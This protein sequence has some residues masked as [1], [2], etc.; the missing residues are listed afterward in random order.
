MRVLFVNLPY[1][2]RFTRRYMCTYTSAS[3]LFPPYELMSVAGEVRSKGKYEVRLIDCVAENLN[4]EYLNKYIDD[5]QPEVIL[6]LIGLD[7]FERDIKAINAIKNKFPQIIQVGFGHYPT[8]FPEEIL[9]KSSLDII[10]KGEPDEVMSD[11]MD[12]INNPEKLNEIQGIAFKN[13]DGSI[14]ISKGKK[15]ILDLNNLAF[16]AHDLIDAKKYFEPFL[17]SPFGMIQT[18]RG[19]PYACNFCVTSYGKKYT[20]KSPKTVVDE[21]LWM[22]QLHNIKSFRIIDD[23]FTIQKQRAID[24]CNLMIQ[25]NLNLKWTCLSRVDTLTEEMLKSMKEAGCIRIYF[26]L[27]SGSEKILKLY[28][29]GADIESAVKVLKWCS[30]LG[31]ETVGL[32]MAGLPN[33]TDEDFQETIDFAKKVDL[34]FA[35]VGELTPYPGTDLYEIYK[36]EIEFSLFPYQLK[37]INPKISNLAIERRN[38]FHKKFYFRA[39]TYKKMTGIAIKNPF[40]FLGVMKNL[41]TARKYGTTL[42]PYLHD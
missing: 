42:Y 33:E 25:E 14:Q 31:I 27:E 38:K 29:K 4:N 6:S 36:K 11:V 16:P 34:T 9:Q 10:I 40:Q 24:I 23:T 19:C 39:S 12:S 2:A 21:L 18:S 35:G 26:G 20:V 41:Y 30:D 22:K 1:P 7:S 3:S 8:T 15:R 17:S 37:F 5:F 32:F 28:N 13:L